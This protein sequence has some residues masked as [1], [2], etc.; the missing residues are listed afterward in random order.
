MKSKENILVVWPN[1]QENR[2][3]SVYAAANSDFVPGTACVRVNNLLVACDA[4]TALH[5][6]LPVEFVWIDGS[7]R[8]DV[9]LI[10]KDG[11]TVQQY[12]TIQGPM[13]AEV[14]VGRFTSPPEAGDVITKSATAGFL[15]PLNAGELDALLETATGSPENVMLII[16][17]VIGVAEK[18]GSGFVLCKF[19]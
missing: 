15:D 2:Q 6:T 11:N 12:T 7:T 16:G 1:D 17:Q 13:I 5:K 18:S 3:R 9:N 10:D 19:T 14:A 4:T 8:H